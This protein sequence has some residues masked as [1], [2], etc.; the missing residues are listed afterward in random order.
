MKKRNAWA[1]GL[2]IGFVVFVALIF[3]LRL[4]VRGSGLRAY[5]IPS[6]AMY[7]TLRPG[8]RVLVDARAYAHSTPQRGD[9]V[10]FVKD[11]EELG[12]LR[13]IKRVIAVG[14]DVIQGDGEEVK[15]NGK[16]LQEPYIA[17][18]DNS[19]DPAISFGPVTVPP[20]QLFVIGDARQN[21]ND[22]RYFGCIDVSQVTGRAFYVWG[23]TKDSS[24]TPHRIR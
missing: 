19:A 24:R 10:A 7:P 23:S 8:D 11:E 15:L 5:I 17:S 9:V 21:S 1:L 16:I 18:V 6:A 13:Y 12:K 2:G 14:G 3:S 20:G 4:V 22:S